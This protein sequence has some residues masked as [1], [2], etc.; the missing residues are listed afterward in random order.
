MRSCLIEFG[1]GSDC[2]Y[3]SVPYRTF[4]LYVFSACEEGA[5]P[6]VVRVNVSEKLKLEHYDKVY[7][8]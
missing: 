7:K 1:F 2:D 5:P 4:V 6:Y 8:H 3:M